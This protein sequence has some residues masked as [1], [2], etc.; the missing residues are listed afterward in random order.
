MGLKDIIVEDRPMVLVGD[1]DIDLIVSMGD[2]GYDE[3]ISIDYD[4][5]E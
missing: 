4:D 1:N 5:D 3:D 2:E